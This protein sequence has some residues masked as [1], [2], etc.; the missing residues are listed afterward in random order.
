MNDYSDHDK[1]SDDSVM[2]CRMLLY[3]VKELT[4]QAAKRANSS[5]NP[6]TPAA[7]AVSRSLEMAP[8][9]LPRRA[10]TTNP[11]TKPSLFHPSS[12]QLSS[13]PLK[14]AAARASADEDLESLLLDGEND[15]P[16]SG[17]RLSGGSSASRD[18]QLDRISPIHDSSQHDADGFANLE[19]DAESDG[20]HLSRREPEM[21]NVTQSLA[22]EDA[23]NHSFVETGREP[24]VNGRCSPCSCRSLNNSMVNV[25]MSPQTGCDRSFSS[26]SGNPG[27]K[28]P[29]TPVHLLSTAGSDSWQLFAET[30]AHMQSARTNIRDFIESE[31]ART[32]DMSHSSNLATINRENRRTSQINAH[33]VTVNPTVVDRTSEGSANH[34]GT[35]NVHSSESVSGLDVVDVTDIGHS[36]H[37]DIS[38]EH[39]EQAEASCEKSCRSWA[40]ILE[41]VSDRCSSGVRCVTAVPQPDLFSSGDDIVTPDML[42]ALKAKIIELKRRQERLE[43]SQVLFAQGRPETLTSNP[44]AATSIET[45]VAKPGSVSNSQPATVLS[46]V[47]AVPSSNQNDRVPLDRNT[48]AS[49]QLTRN[50]VHH[51]SAARNLIFEFTKLATASSENSRLRVF[52]P[53][54]ITDISCYTASTGVTDP[55]DVAVDIS[56]VNNNNKLLPDEI[57][58]YMPTASV[59]QMPVG[60]TVSTAVGSSRLFLSS[61]YSSAMPIGSEPG[62]S[63]GVLQTCM[64]DDSPDQASLIPTDLNTGSSSSQSDAEVSGGISTVSKEAE[65]TDV[66]PMISGTLDVVSTATVSSV[67]SCSSE[68]SACLVPFPLPVTADA[69]HT[70]MAN[71]LDSA[72]GTLE[73]NV[74]PTTSS[75]V[76]VEPAGT[77]NVVALLSTDRQTVDPA[78]GSASTKNMSLLQ[79]TT[80]APVET[81]PVSSQWGNTENHYDASVPD[82]SSVLPGSTHASG[83]IHQLNEDKAMHLPQ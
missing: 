27:T 41:Q 28:L 76:V 73:P 52:P 60:E 65:S 63:V 44:S 38:G 15:L 2:L 16:I 83:M 62:E 33:L 26:G 45:S 47:S 70:L 77:G 67:K 39:S 80:P 50:Q 48:D 10:F 68:T 36:S 21:W 81:H 14:D 57:K 61:V 5:L 11:A 74:V 1:D 19:D 55:T 42:D 17:H 58:S 56:P 29:S 72:F 49:V 25:Q 22:R 6:G 13:T 4:K 75:S 37:Q 43:R 46:S 64:M 79:L 59:F 82:A 51:T 34:N 7:A 31:K 78:G 8:D 69:G 66:V 23:E 35:E 53:A 32:A 12:I 71:H 54:G 24:M 30:K 18:H 3:R 20:K 9:I 40:E